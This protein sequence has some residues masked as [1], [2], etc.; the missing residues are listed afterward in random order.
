MQSS[1]AYM[2][3]CHNESKM[4]Y[5]ILRAMIL[6]NIHNCAEINHVSP[7]QLGVAEKGYIPPIQII[8]GATKRRDL[9]ALVVHTVARKCLC[10]NITEHKRFSLHLDQECCRVS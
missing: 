10:T 8:N 3:F 5:C 6:Q 7:I 9:D 2:Y 4:H 1:V